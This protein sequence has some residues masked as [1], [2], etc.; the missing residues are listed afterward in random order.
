MSKP[1]TPEALFANIDRRL[2]E[3]AR[4][5]LRLPVL[6]AAPDEIAAGSVW[7]RKDLGKMYVSDGA[8]VYEVG[9]TLIS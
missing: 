8:H 9:L 1:L 2:R 4:R 7:I 6:T 5:S 3:L